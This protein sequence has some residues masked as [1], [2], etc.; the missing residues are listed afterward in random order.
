MYKHTNISLKYKHFIIKTYMFLPDLNKSIKEIIDIKTDGNVAGFAKSLNISQQKINRLFNI[1]TRTGKYP[2][3]PSDI[4]TCITEMFDDVDAR[5]LLTGKQ[6]VNSE[7]NEPQANYSILDCSLCREKEKTINYLKHQLNRYEKDIDW[8]Q[9]KL[10]CPDNAS[11][12]Q[13]SA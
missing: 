11:T 5:W 9:R 8:L 3:V 1:D 7:V 4:L 2:T 6:S 12:K 10:D 13:K